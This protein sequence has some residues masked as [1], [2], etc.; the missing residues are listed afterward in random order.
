MYYNARYYD[1]AMGTFI[2]PD[3]IVPSPNLAIDYNRCTYARAN[4]LRLLDPSGNG[5]ACA[6]LVSL[7]PLHASITV[8]A[9]LCQAGNAIY[10]AAAPYVPPVLQFGQQWLD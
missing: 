6:N 9:F 4:P 5:A 8:L 10:Q 2:S 1:P 3:T 7:R